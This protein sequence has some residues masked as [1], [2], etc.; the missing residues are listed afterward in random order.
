LLEDEITEFFYDRNDSGLPVRWVRMMKESIFTVCSQFNMDRVLS[1]YVKK[2]YIPAV[3]SGAEIAADDFKAAKAVSQEEAELIRCWDGIRITDCSCNV[4]KQ[5]H[6]VEGQDMEVKCTVALGQARSDTVT[7][8]L[9]YMY[10]ESHDFDVTAMTLEKQQDGKAFYS[11]QLKIK[12]Y[13]LQ[14]FNVRIRPANPLVADCNPEL[15]KWK[16]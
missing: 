4:D 12:G 16:D 15:I 6:I 13:G 14:S 1:S 7:V 3:K 9:F 8:E 11:T 10:H 2:F 5:E